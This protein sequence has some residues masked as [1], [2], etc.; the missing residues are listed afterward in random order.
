M[1]L[2]SQDFDCF[3]FITIFACSVS[4]HTFNICIVLALKMLLLI[5]ITITAV[6]LILFVADPNLP[7]GTVMFTNGV[8]YT[9][10]NGMAIFHAPEGGYPIP[11]PQVRSRRHHKQNF[12][13]ISFTLLEN[14]CPHQ[15]Y[16]CILEEILE[17]K[18]FPN[19]TNSK[20]LL[21]VTFYSLQGSN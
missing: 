6:F 16:Q 13:V 18:N 3:L 7:T 5:P 8:P 15:C 1:L 14:Y 9:Y 19:T 20:K 10:Q 21:V 11:Q 12:L 17:N 4:I 2:L